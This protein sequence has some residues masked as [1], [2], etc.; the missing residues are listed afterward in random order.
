[1]R[2]KNVDVYLLE[3][4]KEKKDVRQGEREMFE[5]CNKENF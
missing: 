2:Y 3:M 4:E 1:M 5:A